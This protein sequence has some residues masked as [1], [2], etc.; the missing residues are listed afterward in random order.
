MLK[1]Y[2]PSQVQDSFVSGQDHHLLIT[3]GYQDPEEPKEIIQI[4]YEPAEIP[5]EM[6]DQFGVGK[7]APTGKVKVDT[8]GY[9]IARRLD[10]DSEISPTPDESQINQ[11]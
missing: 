4:V 2:E 6:I 3:S 11:S 8:S 1:P 10:S 5:K 9:Y 7:Q